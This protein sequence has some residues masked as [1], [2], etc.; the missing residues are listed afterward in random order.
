M[1]TAAAPVDPQGCTHNNTPSSVEALIRGI[2]TPILASTDPTSAV[3]ELDAARLR[4]LDGV[5]T[6]AATERRLEAQ[7]REYNIA[8]GFTPVPVHSGRTEEVRRRGGHLGAEMDNADLAAPPGFRRPVYSTP[9]KNMRAAQAAMAEFNGL[10]GEELQLQH[11]RIRDLIDAANRSR[12]PTSGGRRAP[13]PTVW[14]EKYH[15]M[16]DQ[17]ARR[18][19]A[20]LGR[21]TRPLPRMHTEPATSTQDHIRTA[22]ADR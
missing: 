5:E 22:T 16:A 10:Q 19:P 9:A 1:V 6:I 13:P 12:P 11:Q 8:H 20:Q 4:L 15:Q 2:S 21:I 3:V 14:L 18:Q 17:S 7:V